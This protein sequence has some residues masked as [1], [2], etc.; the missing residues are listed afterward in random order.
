MG[1]EFRCG[2]RE[3]FWGKHPEGHYVSRWLMTIWGPQP[4]NA[5]YEIDIKHDGLRH[6]LYVRCEKMGE[7]KYRYPMR[8]CV[9][10]G[11]PTPRN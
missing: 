2:A 4:R 8:I 9:S 11:F 7:G 1:Q 5:A 3:L 10:A 6:Y